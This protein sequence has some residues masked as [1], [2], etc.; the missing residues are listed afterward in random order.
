MARYELQDEAETLSI[1]IVRF[2]PSDPV[3]GTTVAELSAALPWKIRRAAAETVI[4]QLRRGE[5]GLDVEAR[6]EGRTPEQRIEIQV[7]LSG[8]GEYGE[9][10]INYLQTGQDGQSRCVAHLIAGIDGEALEPRIL[11]T[12]WGIGDGDMPLGLYPCRPL[13]KAV[14]LEGEEEL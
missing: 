3:D 9:V 14:E 7:R 6:Y 11:S 1:F 8:G 12:A 2:G 4:A 10:D 13:N 5:V